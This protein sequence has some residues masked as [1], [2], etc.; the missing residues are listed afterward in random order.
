[1]PIAEM[2]AVRVALREVRRAVFGI[3]Q[4]IVDGFGDDLMEAR[5]ISSD[6]PGSF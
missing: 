4:F 5:V 2:W 6:L 1:M 3:Q